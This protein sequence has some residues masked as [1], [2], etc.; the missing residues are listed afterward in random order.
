VLETFVIV[1]INVSSYSDLSERSI[2]QTLANYKTFDIILHSL[3]QTSSV[4]N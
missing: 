2:T 3:I 1:W 4:T